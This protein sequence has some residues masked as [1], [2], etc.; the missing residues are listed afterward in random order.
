MIDINNIHFKYNDLDLQAIHLILRSTSVELYFGQVECSSIN[1]IDVIT[2]VI[3]ET[4]E[5]RAKSEYIC[6]WYAFVLFCDK[7]RH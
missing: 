4:C 3:T 5:I 6:M 1:L 2:S 7:D